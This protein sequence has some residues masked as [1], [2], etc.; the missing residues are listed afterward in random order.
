MNQSHM[1]A[2]PVGVSVGLG[3]RREIGTLDDMYEFLDEWAPSRRSEKHSI[4]MKACHA[5]R[6]GILTVEQAERAFR[7]F[8]RSIDILWDDDQIGPAVVA[9]STRRTQSDHIG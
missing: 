1:F 9:R 7:M 8:A 6:D 3:L 4:A 5:A 2:S